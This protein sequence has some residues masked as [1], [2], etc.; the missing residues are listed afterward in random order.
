MKE[1]EELDKSFSKSMFIT[2]VNNIFVQLFT[3]VMTKNLDKI[4]HFIGENVEKEFDEKIK[5]LKDN[6]QIQMYDELNVKDTRILNYQ[7]LD[8]KYVIKVE[9]ISRYMDYLIDEETKEYISGIDDHRI[10][11]I[12]H[13]T[14]EKKRNAKEYKI[15][16][17]CPHCGNSIDLN[18]NGHCNYCGGIFDAENYDYILTSI[19]EI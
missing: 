15:V 1:L 4:R 8:D 10:E 9:L 2:K 16:K 14:F 12:Y 7:I 17:M 5:E 18:Q 11:K 6:H 3:A 13:L 19:K